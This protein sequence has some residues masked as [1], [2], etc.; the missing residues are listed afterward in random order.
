MVIEIFTPPRMR[1][2]DAKTYFIYRDASE[3][4]HIM[5][6]A[7]RYRLHVDL[8]YRQIRFHFQRHKRLWRRQKAQSL[9]QTMSA[10][11]VQLAQCLHQTIN[12][13]KK[14]RVEGECWLYYF[15]LKRT[16]IE[17]C[18]LPIYFPNVLHSSPLSYA[19]LTFPSNS[20]PNPI[21]PS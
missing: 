11:I 17:K 12:P 19:P 10:P 8:E 5:F 13:D 4:P 1:F 21:Y 9:T 7:Y 18:C 20:T 6:K 16:G 2:L 14:T 15:E 3:S